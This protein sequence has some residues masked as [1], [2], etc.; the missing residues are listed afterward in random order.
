M[1]IRPLISILIVSW[2]TKELLKLCVESIFTCL[3]NVSYEII[4]VDNDSQDGSADMIE[5]IFQG[6]DHVLVRNQY[7]AGFAQANNQALQHAHG[8]FIALVNSDI[9]FKDAALIQMV[10]FLDQTPD[11]GL[12]SCNLVGDDGV[13]QSIH[14]SF[15]TLPTIFFTMTRLG[16]SLDARLL[17]STFNKEYKLQNSLRKGVKAVDQA[18]AAMIVM[19]EETINLLGGL[20]D[21]RFPIYGND[22]DLCR[23]VRDLGLKILVLYDLEVFHKGSASLDKL[24]PK[25]KA[26]MKRQWLHTYYEKYQSSMECFILRLMIPKVVVINPYSPPLK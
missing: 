26:I 21:E 15:P 22:V 17:N 20:F 4:V 1:N 24:E 9:M 2:N 14:R 10:N 12:V 13:S 25:R 7:N 8:E 19:K 6:S 3:T 18:A 23:R 16:V 11:C 5:S